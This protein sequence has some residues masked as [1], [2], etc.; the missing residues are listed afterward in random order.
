MSNVYILKCANESFYIGSTDNLDRRLK[1]HA[2]GHTYST[3]RLGFGELVLSQ[4][5]ASLAD[6]RSVEHK[7]KLL[8]R[9]D[10][11]AKIV[12]DGYIRIVP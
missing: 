2:A 11:V 9:C 4:E 12:K 8:K 7:L 3:R 6:A 10:Y 1:Q 5:Y